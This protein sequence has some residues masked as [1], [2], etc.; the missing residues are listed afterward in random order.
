MAFKPTICVDFDGVIH[1]YISGWKGAHV[2]PDPPV[3]GALE[4]LVRLLDAGFEV[5]VF[6]SR[7]KSLRGRWAMKR[8][9]RQWLVRTGYHEGGEDYLNVPEWWR[10]KV[11][12]TAFA[13]PWNAEVAYAARQIVR[14]IKWPWFKPA[15]LLTID[16]RALCFDGNWSVVTPEA[17]RSF[18]P[19]NKR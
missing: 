6:S 7:S 2:I 1:S 10:N 3:R 19:W 18:K 13:D 8:W 4:A 16:D 11:A 17:I 5:A 9:V 15:A 12:E 14:Q